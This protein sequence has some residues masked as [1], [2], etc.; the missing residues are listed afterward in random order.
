MAEIPNFRK[1][2]RYL[3]KLQ[4]KFSNTSREYGANIKMLIKKEEIYKMM[5]KT[6]RNQL[7]PETIKTD[8][9]LNS[10]EE[11]K[12]KKK[13][14]RK[15]KKHTESQGIILNNQF[16]TSSYA[17][18]V[19]DLSESLINVSSTKKGTL[20]NKKPK[21]NKEYEEMILKDIDKPLL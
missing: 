1:N 5:R 4:D 13:L 19:L 7:I 14:I 17:Q 6:K 2:L 16:D 3:D 8:N 9:W 10:I 11:K 21:H 12:E 20:R 18:S 15:K